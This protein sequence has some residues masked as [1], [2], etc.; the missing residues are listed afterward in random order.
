VT[1]RLD[2]D[3]SGEDRC[4]VVVVTAGSGT[5]MVDGESVLLKSG[6]TILLPASTRQLSVTGAVTFAMVTIPE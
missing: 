2:I 4:M 3:W 1:T 6:D 5:L